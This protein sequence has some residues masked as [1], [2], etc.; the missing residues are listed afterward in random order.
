MKIAGD[1]RSTIISGVGRGKELENKDSAARVERLKVHR[2]SYL[3]TIIKLYDLYADKNKSR[4]K[5][6]K[7]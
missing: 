2:L 5:P 1:A 6:K 3:K 4:C 7:K